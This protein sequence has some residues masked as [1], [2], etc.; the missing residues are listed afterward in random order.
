[1]GLCIP[2]S[3]SRRPGSY[4][5]YSGDSI[6]PVPVAQGAQDDI[7]TLCKCVPGLWFDVG[8]VVRG[9]VRVPT[10]AAVSESLL[11]Q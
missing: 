3:T 11:D 10:Y 1:M 6:S 5:A 2:Q 4:S 9:D 8:D 7:R